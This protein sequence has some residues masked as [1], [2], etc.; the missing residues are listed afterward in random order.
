V[1][2][3]QCHEQLDSFLS[4]NNAVLDECELVFSLVYKDN[5]AKKLL[6]DSPDDQSA[7]AEMVRG[8]LKHAKTAYD[9]LR[10]R[11]K[12]I[13]TTEFDDVR[14][15]WDSCSTVQN[16]IRNYHNRYVMRILY[17]LLVIKDRG[18]IPHE[19][20]RVRYRCRICFGRTWTQKWVR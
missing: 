19:I 9:L 8:S 3:S 12:G 11:Y 13:E 17:V 2:V 15:S 7:Q 16:G 18:L 6:K 20:P 1:Q 10:E 5:K 4:E 14:I